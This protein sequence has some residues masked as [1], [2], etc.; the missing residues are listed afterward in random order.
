MKIIFVCTGNTCRSPMAESF[1]YYYNDKYGLDIKSLSRGLMARD[2]SSPNK[3]AVIA[4]KSYDLDINDHRSNSLKQYEIDEDTLILAM[5]K[6]HIDYI[7]QTFLV[8]E[9]QLFL[10]KG[11]AGEEE[12]ITD[13]FGM[14]QE[15]YNSC[16]KEIKVSVKNVFKKL[17]NL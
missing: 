8:E 1:A 5:T 14:S 7:K 3:N 10:L 4:M 13:P 17:T 2:G 15:I 6:H 9:N 16:A 11:F 12:E